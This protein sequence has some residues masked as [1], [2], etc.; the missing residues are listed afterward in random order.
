MHHACLGKAQREKEGREKKKKDVYKMC[1]N[2]H[3]NT[4]NSFIITY[5]MTTHCCQQTF[6]AD[7]AL[8]GQ[9]INA[10]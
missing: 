8:G 3:V 7:V 1:V 5:T 9:G 4:I 2:T 10:S 6:T